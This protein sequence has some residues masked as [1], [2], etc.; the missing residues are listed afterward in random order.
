MMD[1]ALELLALLAIN[2]LATWRIVN[3]VQYEDG[4]YYI[5]RN[6]RKKYLVGEFSRDNPD[7]SRMSDQEIAEFMTQGLNENKLLTPL[8]NCF[9]CTSVWVSFVIAIGMLFWSILDGK[10]LASRSLTYFALGF[11]GSAGAIWLEETWRKFF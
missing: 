9:W 10:D 1:I 4:P 8:L 2:A 7:I 3:M 6:L 11:A 5:F